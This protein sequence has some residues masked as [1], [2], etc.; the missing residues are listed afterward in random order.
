[1]K[2]YLIKRLLMIILPMFCITVVVFLA[3][4]L[5]PGDPINHLLADASSDAAREA[6]L[7]EDG[8]DHSLYSQHVKWIW[9]RFQKNWGAL[10]LTDRS[11]LPDGLIKLPG[12]IELI[13]F[14]IT[15][16]VGDCVWPLTTIS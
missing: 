5:I 3:T 7:R 1:M 8:L 2:D 13:L 11:V 4:R 10:I 16:E 12:S 9:Q 15:A 14:S 6:L